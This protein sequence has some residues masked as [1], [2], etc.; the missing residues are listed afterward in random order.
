M[1][2]LPPTID[3]F[4][5]DT[6]N[7]VEGDPVTL[8]WAASDTEELIL[9]VGDVVETIPPEEHVGQREF[10]PDSNTLFALEARNSSAAVL[11]SFMVWVSPAAST[12]APIIE[13]FAATPNEVVRG[14][15]SEIQLAWS[16]VG[17]T[18]NIEISSLDAFSESNLAAR[19]IVTVQVDKA[20]VFVLTAVNG[21]LSTSQSVAVGV[22]EPIP[23]SGSPTSPSSER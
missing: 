16:V 21:D 22:Y 19:D 13:F 3:A 7:I 23:A 9:R 14:H 15:S 12:Q 2:P 10:T 4:S 1:V 11:K 20:T 18:T 8:N 17:E 5:V 6:Q